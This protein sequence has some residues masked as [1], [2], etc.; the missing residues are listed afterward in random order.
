MTR[1]LLYLD[2]TVWTAEICLYEIYVLRQIL[3]HALEKEQRKRRVLAWILIGL[4]IF[5]EWEI[6]VP[7]LTPFLVKSPSQRIY[8]NHIL[9]M[10][11]I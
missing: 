6:P 11:R 1:L 4:I 5:A 7:F 2:V 8:L 3:T 10:L 9:K